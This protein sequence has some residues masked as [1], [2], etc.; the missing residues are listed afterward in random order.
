[1]SAIAGLAYLDGR[2]ADAGDIAR[3]LDRV[4]HRGPDGCGVWS[5]G[6]VAFGHRMLRTTPESASE[7]Q[8]LAN[9]TGD[10]ILTADA[11]VDNRDELLRALGPVAPVV[12]G[13]DVPDSAL[14]LA[15]YERW[16]E[17]FCERLVGDF[18]VAIW[19]AR[20][21][22]LVCARDH[23][24]VKPFYYHTSRG[25]FAFGSELKQLLVLP[26]IPHRVEETRVGDYLAGMMDDEAIT[27]YRDI[28]RLPSAHR[29]VVSREGIRMERY[30]ALDPERELRCK[31]DADYA[32]GF[33]EHF[34]EA[35]RCRLRSAVPVGSLLSGGL[36]SSSIVCA[37][38]HIRADDPAAPALHTFS[39]IFPDLPECDERPFIDAVLEG[40]G[41]EP[42]F[43]RGDQL[44][45][46][47]ELDGTLEQQDEPFYTPNVFLVWALYA[48]A[49]EHG[50]RVMLDGVDGDS[51]I[52][53]GTRYLTELARAGRWDE[54]GSEA[55]LLAEGRQVPPRHYL[56]TQGFPSLTERARAGDMLAVASAV[57]TIGSRF[58]ISRWGVVRDS[59]VRPL[60]IEPVLRR[61]RRLRAALPAARPGGN[62]RSPRQFARHGVIAPEFARRAALAERHGAM[63]GHRFDLMRTS[64]EDHLRRLSGGL[65]RVVLEVLD[66]VASAFSVEPRYPFC[67]KRLVEYCLALPADQKLRGGWTRF[68]LRDALGFLPDK[69]RWRHDKGDLSANFR[70]AFAADR[71]RVEAELFEGGGALT[72]H[73]DLP[74]LRRA[75][76]D[77]SGTGNDDAAVTAWRV[78]TISAWLRRRNISL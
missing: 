4:Q 72:N 19:D 36:D 38:R 32:E 44:G 13:T 41:L 49:R 28:V 16:G 3:M 74:A 71:N 69:V 39:A 73:I 30:W 63:R 51:T 67:D 1:M 15:A 42:H 8:P 65:L 78:A 25:L 5:D 9:A 2:S 53:H 6:W 37:A 70:R 50:V 40:G 61:W 26:E 24:G 23:M 55:T 34:T 66:H 56:R 33:R 18:A 60:A 54:F 22:A 77:G 14:I 57:R 12:G 47:A 76:D 20:R 29:L 48:S 11:R 31:S 45:A 75:W 64:R 59:V 21:K 58:G 35:V 62:D 43:V 10:L 7:R 46:L 52:S 68:I 17:A 27:F